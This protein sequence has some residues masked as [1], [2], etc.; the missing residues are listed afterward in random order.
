MSK[1]S[2][3]KELSLLFVLISFSNVIFAGQLNPATQF[4]QRVTDVIRADDLEALKKITALPEFDIND[5][6]Y[7]EVT[8]RLDRPRM[9]TYLLRKGCVFKA[10]KWG[11]SPFTLAVNNLKADLLQ[12]MID[13]LKE[14]GH[15]SI[16]PEYVAVMN[17]R[18]NYSLETPV[19]ILVRSFPNEPSEVRLRMIKLL[20]DNG[21]D[22][23]IPDRVGRRPLGTAQSTHK[24]PQIIQYLIDKG[25]Y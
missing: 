4:K 15:G 16:S 17:T 11:V 14:R 3:T 6:H 23:N 1:K 24:S 9:M 25:A 22:P 18:R 8:A 20:V 21:A 5:P 13:G 2:M 10:D 12:A 19:Y 7:V